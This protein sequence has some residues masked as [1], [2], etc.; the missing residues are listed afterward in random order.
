MNKDQFLTAARSIHADIYDYSLV[1]YVNKNTNVT[2]I[3][4]EHG[5]FAIT[6]A[7]HLKRGACNKCR[8]TRFKQNHL[9]NAFVQTATLLYL[10]KYNYS[11]SVYIDKDTPICIISIH[12]EFYQTPRDHL[13]NEDNPGIEYTPCD[14]ILYKNAKT[15]SNFVQLATLKHGNK[16]NYFKSVYYGDDTKLQIT[17]RQHGYLLQMPLAHLTN[18][19]DCITCNQQAQEKEEYLAKN[20][21]LQQKRAELC[22]FVINSIQMAQETGISLIP[23]Y[24][25]ANE[26][27][28]ALNK[29]STAFKTVRTTFSN[30]LPLDYNRNDAT[31]LANAQIQLKSMLH[32]DVEYTTSKTEFQNLYTHYKTADKDPEYS[33]IKKT[34][35]LYELTDLMSIKTIDIITGILGEYLSDATF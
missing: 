30:N 18:D 13:E 25:D 14:Y 23:H 16:Y 32:D 6:P 12:G 9:T 28:T 3:C 4:K 1:N 7:F 34:V 20:T 33:V 27:L 5:E 17:C 22:L 8:A 15:S 19:D 10:D 26:F 29:F 24:Q 21:P 35:E 2:L 31:K 11:K